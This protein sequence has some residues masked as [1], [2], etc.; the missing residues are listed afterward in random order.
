M[1][2]QTCKPA[3][4]W[5]GSGSPDDIV[6]TDSCAG[7][8][9]NSTHK[10]QHSR[11]K[12]PFDRCDQGKLM[13]VLLQEKP[14]AYIGHPRA[15]GSVFVNGHVLTSAA[16]SCSST[17]R[18]L[19]D[20]PCQPPAQQHP[21]QG[22]QESSPSTSFTKAGSSIRRVAVNINISISIIMLIIT[23]SAPCICLTICSCI[24]ICS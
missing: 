4:P 13:A 7:A 14:P 10:Q 23:F 2:A 9:Y 15:A 5:K 17:H 19:W 20:E 12:P 11:L 16:G 6:T 21:C 24:I 1:A 18:S 3:Q 8:R 22:L